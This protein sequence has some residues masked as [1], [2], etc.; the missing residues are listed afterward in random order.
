MSTEE[1]NNLYKLSFDYN[2][3]TRALLGAILELIEGSEYTKKLRK[4]LNNITSYK[5]G[6]NP[7]IIPNKKKWNIQ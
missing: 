3:A 6:I 2:P 5:I 7:E 4:T 1:R